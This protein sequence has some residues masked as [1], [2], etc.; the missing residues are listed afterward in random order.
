MIGDQ[1]QKVSSLNSFLVFT[2]SPKPCHG[3]PLYRVPLTTTLDV[4]TCRPLFPHGL[5]RP[6]ARGI[7]QTDN[8]HPTSNSAVP[9]NVA[10]IPNSHLLGKVACPVVHYQITT[11]YVSNLL[12]VCIP[13]NRLWDRNYPTVH[14][15]P[16][17]T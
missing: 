13:T 4:F 12:F 1:Q 3:R 14:S 10:T 2:N 16:L 6:G 9:N 11:G 17:S 8:L 5:T 7:H 15:H